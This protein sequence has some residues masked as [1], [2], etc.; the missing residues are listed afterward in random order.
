[1]FILSTYPNTR[2][3]RILIV[4]AVA[5]AIL[6]GCGPARNVGSVRGTITDAVTLLPIDGAEVTLI[7]TAILTATT[8]SDG[9]YRLPS[10]A[11]GTYEVKV[12]KDG[13]VD[14]LGDGVTV[15]KSAATSVSMGMIRQA[16]LKVLVYDDSQ[17]HFAADA[18]E[19]LGIAFTQVDTPDGLVDEMTNHAWHL[20]VADHCSYSSSEA[21][22]NCLADYVDMGGRLAISSWD[23]ADSA[24]SRA[25]ALWGRLGAD[26]S[27]FADDDVLDEDPF[28]V[29]RW[30]ADHEIFKSPNAVPD[31]SVDYV[32]DYI[33]EGTVAHESAGGTA[34]AG[35]THAYQDGEGIVFVTDSKLTV[36]NSF[37]LD[38]TQDGTGAGA[39]VDSD[40]EELWQ[41]EIVYLLSWT[42]PSAA[43]CPPIG[44]SSLR[45]GASNSK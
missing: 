1:M 11:A 9:S 44:P 16:D 31:I 27:G 7:S 5:S 41:N 38:C 26:F 18:L 2:V 17:N 13:Y 33:V 14:R 30:A 35:I 32:G 37:L 21:M 3:M 36:F 34:V 20:I 28:T 23:P 29:F 45:A 8:G 39:D 22:L 25:H 19:A 12:T 40:A 6:A 24:S 4:L 15:T 42:D 43:Q 10:V